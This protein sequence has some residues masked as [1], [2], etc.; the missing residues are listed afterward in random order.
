MII[1]SC[2][3]ITEAEIASAVMELLHEDPWRVIAPVQIYHAL[4][5]RGKCCSCFPNVIE[6]IVETTEAFHRAR[7]TPGSDLA[8]LIDTQRRENIAREVLRREKRARISTMNAA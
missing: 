1:C 2:N 3:V 6:V 8:D 4:G 5:K 7:Q